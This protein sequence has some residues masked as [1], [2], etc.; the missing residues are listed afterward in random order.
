MK[1]EEE[2]QDLIDLYAY[3]FETKILGED[4]YGLSAKELLEKFSKA[5]IDMINRRA[6]KEE[7]KHLKINHLN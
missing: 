6:S 7:I 3:D 2:L 4:K 1:F 5:L